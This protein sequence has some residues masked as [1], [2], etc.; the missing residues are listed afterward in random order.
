MIL[1]NELVTLILGLAALAFFVVG[2]ARIKNLPR[3]RLF[4]LAF[5]A[6]SAAWVLTVAEGFFL[7]TA[8]NLIEHI[9]YAVSSIAFAL[10]CWRISSDHQESTK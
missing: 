8:L 7:P 6:L 10:W 9:C 2:R 1:Q 3:W 4:L 5:A